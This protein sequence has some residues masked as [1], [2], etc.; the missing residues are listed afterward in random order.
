MNQPAAAPAVAGAANYGPAV[1]KGKTRG[2]GATRGRG[3]RRDHGGGVPRA[4]GDEY[5]IWEEEDDCNPP[6]FA[7]GPERAAGLHLPQEFKDES[8]LDFF[9]LFFFKKKSS[10]SK[11]L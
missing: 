10:K 3:G 11:V 5:R 7:F 1:G 9:N 6:V 4:A 8:E 2:R